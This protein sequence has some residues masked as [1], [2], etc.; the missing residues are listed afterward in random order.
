MTRLAGPFRRRG[1]AVLLFT[2]LAAWGTSMTASA[3][4][5]LAV[6][7]PRFELS[8]EPGN[9]V[10]EILEL[11][12]NDSR[13]GLYKFRT[14][15]WT[16]RPDGTVD[17]TDELAP[18]SCRPWVAIERRE[19]S[20]TPGRPY[21]FRFEVAPPADTPPMECRFAI[22]IEGDQPATMPGSP[23]AL[24][25][26]IGVV[27]Y[28]AIGGAAPVLELAGTSVQAVGGAPTPVVRIRNRGNAHGRLAGFLS[29]TDAAGTKLEFQ[30]GTSPILPGETRDIA[31]LATR[32]GNTDAAVAVRFPI[33]ISGK[34]EW[35]KNGS[36]PIDHRFSQ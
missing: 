4:F 2:G 1:A 10:R 23:V 29:G 16:L 33:T 31:L 34:L 25:A 32:P 36:T 9:R 28:V 35:G 17:F 13:A 24:G 15:D 12:H 3:Q 27:V 26:R 6:S 8:A 30:P 18:G 5:S 14:A 19:V 21:R 11:T 22:M 20:V 7:P